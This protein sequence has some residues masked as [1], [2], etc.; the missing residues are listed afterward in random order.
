ME[1]RGS[2]KVSDIIKRVGE[3]MKDKLKS[4]DF[5]GLPKHPKE[6]RW[7]TAK[8]TRKKMI[9][10]GLLRSDSAFNVW[11]ISEEGRKWLSDNMKN[12]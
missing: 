2:A 9:D 11:E 6:I 5:E 7:H 8:F 3:L 10:D 12:R 4:I 1:F